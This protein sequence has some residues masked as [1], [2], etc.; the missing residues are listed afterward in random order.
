MVLYGLTYYGYVRWF[1]KNV[2]Q[3]DPKRMTPARTYMDGVEFFPTNK[4]VLFGFQWKSIAALG[5][6]WD[7]Y[8]LF[9]GAGYLPCSGYC[10]GTY[11]L[12]G[13]TTTQA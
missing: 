4:Y 5:R 9:S 2:I 6:F 12:V 3:S 8:L 13:S 7:R 1:D 11:S 10:S